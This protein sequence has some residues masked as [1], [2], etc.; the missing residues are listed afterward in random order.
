VAS[1]S[2]YV[3]AM[4]GLSQDQRIILVDDNSVVRDM[5]VDLGGA[6]CYHADG[7][8][9]GEEALALFD[10]GHYDVVLTDLLMPGMI[11]WDVLEAVRQRDSQIPIIIITGSP[12]VGDPRAVRPGVAVLKK[13]VDVRTLGAMIKRMLDQRLPV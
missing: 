8:A 11:G 4:T 10:Q 12:V 1:A 6:L 5:L 9:S 13:P 7:A 2:H 3:K